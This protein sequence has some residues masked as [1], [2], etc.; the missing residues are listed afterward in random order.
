M[1]RSWLV[2][3]PTNIGPNVVE[4]QPS[5]RG[6]QAVERAA[7]S[8]G[9]AVGRRALGDQT[10]AGWILKRRLVKLLKITAERLALFEDPLALWRSG[11]RK[12]IDVDRDFSI[13]AGDD[14]QVVA[15]SR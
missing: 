10:A 8:R 4:A 1:S 14:R 5:M 7:G 3:S 13:H 2:Q 15:G 11:F 9:V 12:L 6:D